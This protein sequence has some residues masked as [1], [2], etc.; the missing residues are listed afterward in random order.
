[1]PDPFAGVAEATRRHREEH[2]CGAYLYRD[3]SL[4]GVIAAAARARRVVEVGTALG[5]SALWLAHGAP[6]ADVDTIEADAEHVELAR[7]QLA[8]ADGG[9]RVH[10]HHGR[11]EQV[12]ATL[13]AGSYD[14]AFFD[15]SAP[16]PE[17]IGGLRERLR[18][19]GVLI[20]GNLSFGRGAA[21]ERGLADPARWLTHSLGETALCI[22]RAAAGG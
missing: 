1:M 21:I 11:G 13:D 3:G 8:A 2:G 12:L 17:L 9:E 15:G 16:T 18:D 10:V 14:V 4:L 7:A 5:Y 20:A 22:K 6:G 19:G